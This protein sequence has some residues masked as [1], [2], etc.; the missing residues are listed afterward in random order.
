MHMLSVITESLV[1][2]CE[3]NICVLKKCN[4]GRLCILKMC[5]EKINIRISRLVGLPQKWKSCLTVEQLVINKTT[6]H[7]R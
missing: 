1:C 4:N 7:F 5:I 2:L 3:R 6:V